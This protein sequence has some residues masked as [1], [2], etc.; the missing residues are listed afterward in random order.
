MRNITTAQKNLLIAKGIDPAKFLAATTAP[1]KPAKKAKKAKQP[2]ALVAAKQ[3]CYEARMNRLSL[4]GQGLTSVERREIAA[5]N[6]KA[7]AKALAK[8]RPAYDA[9]WAKLVAAYKLENYGI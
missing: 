6:R 5:D 4:P 8:G 9:K 7:L 3:H 2:K 1:A